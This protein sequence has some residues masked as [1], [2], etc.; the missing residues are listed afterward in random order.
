MK[1]IILF[2]VLIFSPLCFVHAAEQTPDQSCN[3]TS[4]NDNLGLS[5]C[6][7]AEAKKQTLFLIGAKVIIKKNFEI[8]AG[9][10][11]NFAVF[12][13]DDYPDNSK[14]N[15]ILTNNI[16]LAIYIIG[17][18]FGGCILLFFVLALKSQSETGTIKSMSNLYAS[19]YIIGGGYVIIQNFFDIMQI[20]AAAA[21]FLLLIVIAVFVTP[22]M[23]LMSVV[24]VKIVD[25]AAKVEADFKAEQIIDG[26]TTVFINDV[27]NR[28]NLIAMANP[29]SG[30]SSNMDD[31]SYPTCFAT[32]NV[33][34]EST[35]LTSV[36]PE[37]VKNTAFCARTIGGFNT[38]EMGHFKVNLK[39]NGSA[40]IMDKIEEMNDR[41]RLEY[42]YLVERNDCA[43]ASQ[44][45]K[46]RDLKMY[47]SCM[48]LEDGYI[49]KLTNGNKIKPINEQPVSK[50]SLIAIKKKFVSELSAV[51]LQSSK[52]EAAVIKLPPAQKGLNGAFQLI[53]TGGEFKKAYQNAIFSVINSVEVDTDVEVRREM[54]NSFYDKLTGNESENNL[55]FNNDFSVHDYAGSIS[56][57]SLSQAQLFRTAN[58]IS[59]NAASRLGF[60]Y[61]DCFNKTNCATASPN[62]LD[63][64]TDA[65]G[66]FIGPAVKAYIA[67]RIWE[68]VA[69][70]ENNKLINAKSKIGFTEKGAKVS[71]DFI[72]N[73][74]FTLG[75]AYLFLFWNLYFTQLM[76]ILDWFFKVIVGTFTLL[77][78][79]IAIGL[80]LVVKGRINFN[81][82]DILR[83]IGFYD[84]LFR[85]VLIC[86]GWVTL[87]IM[88]YFSSAINSILIYKHTASYIT[89]IGVGD[90][91]SDLIS[92]VMFNAIY[93]FLMIIGHH[94]SIVTVNKLID[95]ED[96]VLFSGTKGA[97]NAANS[98]MQE[99]KGMSKLKG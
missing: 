65:M 4:L 62:A 84:V 29:L 30:F 49:V 8:G 60:N 81:Y 41:V 86:L 3:Q 1:K 90:V 69:Q 32:K 82:L 51:I 54:L 40:E 83:E 71:A 24:D 97:L 94:S 43:L 15:L 87:I 91:A 34:S 21:I 78:G 16:E 11:S 63:Q 56:D 44:K 68:S 48:D 77:L 38:Y 70:S 5:N 74:M 28:K 9:F 17:M 64:A 61:E 36:I 57:T 98:I 23:A 79:L 19:V 46:D 53:G 73:I 88:L 45:I 10:F 2:L 47:T 66:S 31:Y 37:S 39:N 58:V 42:A 96:A 59:G 72:F 85:P 12:S 25:Q 52:D 33:K 50:E 80:E 35:N 55:G 75:F 92:I 27:R 20:A 76:K 13:S 7:N 99:V 93:L 22:F 67:L 89:F 6:I 18:I 26:L 14:N 95:E